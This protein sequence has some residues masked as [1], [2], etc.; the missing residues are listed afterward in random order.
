[1]DED[2]SACREEAGDLYFPEQDEA[3]QLISYGL[4]L[5]GPSF[6]LQLAAQIE[7]EESQVF[8]LVQAHISTP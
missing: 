6:A 7:G 2:V 3:D 4:I 5:Q 8:L 1:V